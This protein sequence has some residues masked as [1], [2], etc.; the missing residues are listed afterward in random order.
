M[1]VDRWNQRQVAHHF[2]LTVQEELVDFKDVLMAIQHQVMQDPTMHHGVRTPVSS[3]V[4][5]NPQPY[6]PT[7]S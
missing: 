6:L 5:F 7:S 4:D 3:S 2:G 1:N